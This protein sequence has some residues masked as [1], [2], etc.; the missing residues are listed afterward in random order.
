MEETKQPQPKKDLHTFSL[1][2]M[3]FV[4]CVGGAYGTEPIIASIGPLLG[5]I[6]MF[7]LPYIV[8]FPMTLI[9]S[10]ISLALPSNSGYIMWF[11]S[12][13]GQF[14]QF[15]TSFITVLSLI[16][17]CL[18]CAVYPT[19]FLSY[20]QQKFPIHGLYEFAI[21]SLLIICASLINFIGIRSV[22]LVSIFIFIMVI[23]PFI[24]FSFSSIP[25]L[26]WTSLT[27]ILPFNYIDLSLFFSVTFWN[28]NGV[29]NSANVVEEIKSPAKSL[30]LALFFLVLATSLSTTIPLAAGS[31]IDERWPNWKEGSFIHVSSLLPIP[32]WGS[33]LS[34]CLFI[35]ALLTSSGLLLNGICFTS[36]RF[37]GIANMTQNSTIQSVLGRI[38]SMFG[39]PDTSIVLTC[40]ITLL[41]ANS[42]SFIELVGVSSALSAFFI[43]GNYLCFFELRRRY[44]TLERPFKTGPTVL[45]FLISLPS[46]LYC[47]LTLFFS[48]CMDESTMIVSLSL[49]VLALVLGLAFVLIAKTQIQPH[50]YVSKLLKQTHTTGAP[51]EVLVHDE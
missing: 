46:I 31:G 51:Y 47:L 40:I 38:N 34:W 14:S 32:F 45:T 21:K 19:L 29:E 9:T 33:T 13:F 26:N 15:A 35:G 44:P 10:E 12:S 48:V 5:I 11:A 20:L 22:G 43:L 7:I 49:I 17:T 27:T 16:A 37:Q 28:M 23:I 50:P 4:S 41:F 36:R 39:T 24:L 3:M 25:F 8:Q 18:D 42:L 1:F 2:A 6:L 30:P